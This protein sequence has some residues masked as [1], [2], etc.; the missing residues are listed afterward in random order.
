MGSPLNGLIGG[1]AMP[2]L[3]SN[4]ATPASSAMRSVNEY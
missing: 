1:Q 3:A 2:F 4:L